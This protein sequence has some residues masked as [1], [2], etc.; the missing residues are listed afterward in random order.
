MIGRRAA[1]GIIGGTLATVTAVGLGIIRPWERSEHPYAP[2]AIRKL[3]AEVNDWKLQNGVSMIDVFPE[4]R[5]ATALLKGEVDPRVYL[6]QLR[7]P[8][9]FST[10]TSNASFTFSPELDV[11]ASRKIKVKLKGGVEYT[12]PLVKFNSVGGLNF[13]PEILNSTLRLAIA[14]KEA[15]QIIDFLDYC[16]LYLSFLKEQ[17]DF[18]LD[19]PENIPTTE[20][21]FIISMATSQAHVQAMEQPNVR[22]WFYDLVDIGSHIR[23]GGVA[24]ANWYNE[25]LKRKIRPT[26]EHVDAGHNIAGFLQAEGYITEKN[27]MFVWTRG[28]A[29]AVDSKEFLYLFNKLTRRDK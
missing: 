5:Q 4:I 14:P 20:K 13:S 8:L 27:D 6:P 7:V 9:G 23:V 3:G 10:N 12:L 15:S 24:F 28:Q 19:N 26:G 29:P 16:K 22:N 21:E 11:N 2:D 25:Q 18:T 1:L 17:G